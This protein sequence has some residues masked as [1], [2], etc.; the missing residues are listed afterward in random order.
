VRARA[1]FL[2]AALALS[3]GPAVA[4][5]T[6]AR[7]A[8]EL[9]VAQA[10]KGQLVEAIESLRLFLAK[11]KEDDADRAAAKSE[12]TALE[13]RV[14]SLDLV[15]IWPVLGVE[16]D[17][18]GARVPPLVLGRVTKVNPGKQVVSARAEGYESL[19]QT[20]EVGEGKRARVEIEL[21]RAIA[22]PAAS[23]PALEA[24]QRT[25]AP[26]LVVAG[27]GLVVFSLGLGLALSGPL[28]VQRLPT[29][30]GGLSDEARLRFTVGDAIC[31]GGLTLVIVGMVVLAVESNKKTPGPVKTQALRG[32]VSF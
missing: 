12:L 15:L 30:D 6:D 22:K 8:R 3:G 4:Q 21:K 10:K 14:G 13:A 17:V 24:R 27:T 7:A 2:A 32:S 11:A 28:E 31:A 1:L 19:T 25:L 23:L 20:V 9:A 5:A 16:V 26:G 29:R 18:N